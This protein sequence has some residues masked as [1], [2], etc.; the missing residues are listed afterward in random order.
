MSLMK[1]GFGDLKIS[2][3]KASVFYL[4]IFY[5]Y[6]LFGISFFILIIEYFKIRMKFIL[7]KTGRNII[8]ELLK[9]ANQLGYKIDFHNDDTAAAAFISN[10]GVGAENINDLSSTTLTNTTSSGIASSLSSSLTISEKSDENNVSII[11]QQQQQQIRRRSSLLQKR[12]SILKDLNEFKMLNGYMAG[13][14][15]DKQTQITTLL[16][17]KY[18]GDI[19]SSFSSATPI[20]RINAAPVAPFNTPPTIINTTTPTPVNSPQPPLSPKFTNLEPIKETN[21]TSTETTDVSLKLSTETT[22][23]PVTPTSARRARFSDNSGGKNSTSIVNRYN[24]N[25][26]VQATTPVVVKTTILKK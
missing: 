20:I 13:E 18:K 5:V 8:C 11:S 9:F 10:A 17:S 12:K 21:T 1:I 24:N 2:L 7:I 26:Q 16:C 14:K 3:A 23:R 4:I 22:T 25:N 15:C 6:I 19:V